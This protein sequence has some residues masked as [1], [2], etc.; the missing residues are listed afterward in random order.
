MITVH[1]IGLAAFIRVIKGFSYHKIPHRDPE[2]KKFIFQF[3]MKEEEFIECK[4]E[5]LNSDFRKFDGEI[6]DL[7][8]ILNS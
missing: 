2:V 1:D 4:T 8:K 5:Y 7:K 3:E 6:K